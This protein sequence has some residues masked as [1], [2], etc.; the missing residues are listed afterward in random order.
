MLLCTYH[1][2]ILLGLLLLQSALTCRNFKQCILVQALYFK[3]EILIFFTQ[4]GMLFDISDMTD[5]QK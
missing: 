5:K 2:F 1:K 4:D 3:N